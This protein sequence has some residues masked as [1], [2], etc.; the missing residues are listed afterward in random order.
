MKKFL[1]KNK[2]RAIIL[3]ILG[4][5]VIFITNFLIQYLNDDQGKVSN[6]EIT[7]LTNNSFTVSWQTERPVVSKV[8][9]SKSEN[10]F[11]LLPLNKILNPDKQV[12]YNDYDTELDKDGS[13][14]ILRDDVSRNIHYVTVYNLDPDT[15][16]HIWVMGDAKAM[17]IDKNIKTYKSPES[18]ND[19]IPVV[20]RALNHYEGEKFA[21]AGFVRIKF[22]S[23]GKVSQIK[24]SNIDITNGGWQMDVS[25]LYDENGN[26]MDLIFDESSSYEGEIY[27]SLGEGIAFGN[28]ADGGVVNNFYYNIRYIPI[29]LK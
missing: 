20:G 6:I 1:Y 18:I 4:I 7:N 12:F 9:V 2:Y 11:Q 19:P 24:S 8:I 21:D 27:T 13:I 22:K 15:E 10:L 17:K 26:K 23:N 3:I 29:N 28:L 16:Y 25:N 5:L 14:S